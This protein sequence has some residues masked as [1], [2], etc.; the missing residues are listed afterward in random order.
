MPQLIPPTA[1][2]HRQWLAARDEWG[3][4]VHQDGAGLHL[5]LDVDSADG[6]AAW[7]RQLLRQSDPAVEPDPGWVHCTYWWIVEGDEV[8]GSI[9]LRHEL[10]AMLLDR[11]GHIGYGVRPSARG[12]GLA[13]W[14]V[15]RVLPYAEGLGLDRVLIACR[16]D[17]EASRR[18]IERCGGVL[19]DIRA[20]G[21]GPVMRFWIRL[22]GSSS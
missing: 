5:G 10:N 6:F 3:R 14:A 9:A 2:L 17:N 8:L 15:A 7:V 18:T 1:R 11:G 16:V 21:D 13:G 20:T 4:G 12:R 19:E 22:P